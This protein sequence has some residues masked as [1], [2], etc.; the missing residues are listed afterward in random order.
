M[1][2]FPCCK[3]N[4]GLNV[5]ERRSDGYHNIETIFYPI[6]LHDNLE[7]VTAQ[8]AS[9]PY[10]L[11]QTGLTL[12]GDP[13]NNLVVKVYN[14]LRE[15][16]KQLPPIEI[17]LHKRI[18]SGAGLGGGSSDA[19]FMMRL[20]NEKYELGM[21][22]EDI[23]YRLSHLGA[24]CT[25]FYHARPA[26]ATG[27]GNELTYLDF[28]L[29]GWNFVLVKPDIHVSTK[30]AYSMVRPKPSAHNLLEAVSRPVETWKDTVKNDFEY[31]V[32]LHHPEIAAI[33]QTLYDMG[34]VY[35]SMSGSGSSVFGLFNRSQPEA[36][37]VF[38]D[39]MVYETRLRKIETDYSTE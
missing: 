16:Y 12:D 13:D 31:S 2:V 9:Q 1:V 23:E 28:D 35:A 6:P 36:A 27:I 34:A 37:D 19:A 26:F 4:L 38:H 8:N 17:W 18:P 24:D 29:R 5:V 39:C 30:Q 10:L 3:I 11:H 7:V 33:K 20:L 32:F 21:D 22:E 14:L 25:F 15:D